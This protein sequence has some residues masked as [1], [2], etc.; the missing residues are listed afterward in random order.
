ML[1]SL[2]RSEKLRDTAMAPRTHVAVRYLCDGELVQSSRLSPE[3]IWARVWNISV[4][5]NSLSQRA[6]LEPDMEL[7]VQMKPAEPDM[8]L[9]MIARV[10]QATRQPKGDWLVRCDSL[11]RATEADLVARSEAPS[12]AR[13]PHHFSQARRVL[14][15]CY[16][17]YSPKRAVFSN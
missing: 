15:A 17:L 10:A 13:P 8:P 3:R 12:L 2:S 11:R 16:G 5:G 7:V 6:Q 4:D 1:H 14:D 9:V